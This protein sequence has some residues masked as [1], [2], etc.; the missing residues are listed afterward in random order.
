MALIMDDDLQLGKVSKLL[1]ALLEQGNTAGIDSALTA[2]GQIGY[3][4]TLLRAKIYN[5]TSVGIMLER[6]DIDTDTAFT[7]PSN[8]KVPSTQAVVTYIANL[9]VSNTRIRGTVNLITAG[10]Y[11][12]GTASAYVGTTGTQVGNGSGVAN[13]IKSGDAWY[14]TNPASF[15]MGPT[16]TNKVSKGDLVIAL[17]DGAGNLDASW[18]VLQS[19]VDLATT[20]IAGVV[21][22]S[23]LAKLQTNA[24]ADADAVVTTSILNSFLANP[25]STDVTAKYVRRTKI[26]QTLTN[27]SNTVTH[28]KNTQDIASVIFINATTLAE[29]RMGWTASTLNTITVSRTGGSQSFIIMISY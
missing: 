20:S 3:D 2:L 18:L 13:A 26:T 21:L 11:P 6:G 9:I 10:T 29:T 22:L 16:A 23:T 8:T 17:T 15:Q 28:S 19:N 4:T 5:G 14:I 27:G 24:G 1:G 25:D 7:S 12:V